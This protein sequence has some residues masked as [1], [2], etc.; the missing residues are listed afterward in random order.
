MGWE[1]EGG[2]GGEEEE[3]DESDVG[4]EVRGGRLRGWG[5]SGAEVYIFYQEAEGMRDGGVAEVQ[6]CVDPF[7]VH[8]NG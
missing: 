2:V 3:G 6:A 5:T 7:L 8:G 1:W 4:L